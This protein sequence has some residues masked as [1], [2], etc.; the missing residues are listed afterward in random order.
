M[1][2]SEVLEKWLQL[3]VND[4][5]WREVAP[6]FPKM[7][8]IANNC[9]IFLQQDPNWQCSAFMGHVGSFWVILGEILTI[10]GHLGP[11]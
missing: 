5:K 2:S 7:P 9:Q 1:S 3:A 6:I 4:P 10:W 8:K 11:F